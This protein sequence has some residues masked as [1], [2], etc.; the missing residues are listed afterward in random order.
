[1]GFKKANLIEKIPYVEI[2]VPV[3]AFLRVG[4]CLTSQSAAS[5]VSSQSRLRGQILS[6]QSLHGT[7]HIT[8]SSSSTRK[9]IYDQIATKVF[10]FKKITSTVSNSRGQCRVVGLGLVGL[11]GLQDYEYECHD[12]IYSFHCYSI[13]IRQNWGATRTYSTNS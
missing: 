11:C 2:R 7:C 4:S 5:A 12:D 13:A 3:G 9:S 6:A 8:N 1:M 10:L